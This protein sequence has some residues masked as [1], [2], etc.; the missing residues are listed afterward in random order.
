MLVRLDREQDCGVWARRLAGPAEPTTARLAGV[1]FAVAAMRT[2]R[3]A[4]A[5]L[6]P[7]LAS[8]LAEGP[9]VVRSTA[10][11]ALAASL[12]A[13]RLAADQLAALLDDPDLGAAVA[14]ALGSVGDHRAVPHSIRLMGTG[15]DVPRLG[16]ALVACARAGADP[17]VLVAA[18]RQVLA[19]HREPCR[20]GR[21]W[22]YCP[23]APA[24]RLLAEL[25]PAAVDAVPDLV[26]RIQAAMDRNDL[27]EP[28]CEIYVLERVGRAAG[29][30]VPL[31]RRYAKVGNSGADLAVRALVMITSDRVVADRFLAERPEQPR[32]CRNAPAL[33]SWLAD[34][35]GLTGRQYQQLRHLFAQPGAMQVR[36]AGALWRCDGPRMTGEL[37]DTLM[38]YL[39]DDLF[40]PEV[41]RV[42][43]AMGEYA[44]PILGRLDQFVRVRHVR[45]TASSG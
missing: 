32:R 44:R 35:G 13:T 14:T 42:F 37:L 6:A 9:S 45:G 23:A 22:R 10:A 15:D 41:L 40:G 21:T 39:D 24:L 7:I 18:A 5:E 43:T 30:A 3:A 33:L 26:A 19:T 38:E 8:M 31:L 4:P 12:T 2:W 16:E 34:H 25:G 11:R 27:G 1:E 17:T 36:T 20:A 29:A 28:L